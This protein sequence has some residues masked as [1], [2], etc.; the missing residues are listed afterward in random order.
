MGSSEVLRNTILEWAEIIYQRL[1][2]NGVS[3]NL[4]QKVKRIGIHG[5]NVIEIYPNVF[6]ETY[7]LTDWGNAFAE[8]T[9]IEAARGYCF[10][11]RDHF[12]I[13]YSGDVVLCCVDFDGRTS[14][15]NL[16]DAS[17][18]EILRSPELEDIVKGFQRGRLVNPYCRR[19][20]GTNSRLASWF[21]PAVSVLGLK[22]LKPFFYR[23]YKLFE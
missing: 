23:K 20:L 11:M 1:G 13:L 15:G 4:S 6:L 7:V 18:L 17:L 14:I 10:G 19:C 21:K 22:V 8:D 16:K 9:I 12:A 2:L 5:W 3:R